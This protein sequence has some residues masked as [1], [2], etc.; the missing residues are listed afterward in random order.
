MGYIGTCLLA[1]FKSFHDTQKL[2][3]SEWNPVLTDLYQL[4]KDEF[5]VELNRT[6][7]KGCSACVWIMPH[8]RLTNQ[9][10]SLLYGASI[11]H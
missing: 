7:E 9:L 3:I 8:Q 6:I 10:F 1:I 4:S 5:C 2:H 11:S